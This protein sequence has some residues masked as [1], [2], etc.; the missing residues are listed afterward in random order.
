MNP[1]ILFQ[2]I[3]KY[4]VTNVVFGIIVWNILKETHSLRIPILV[5]STILILSI[6]LSFVLQDIHNSKTNDANVS[7][8]VEE[9]K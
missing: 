9:W 6:N 5:M 3:L 4:L 1:F 2:K 7:G 8:G